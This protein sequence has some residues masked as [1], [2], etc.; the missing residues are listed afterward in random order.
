MENRDSSGIQIGSRRDGE[1]RKEETEGERRERR[2]KEEERGHRSIGAPEVGSEARESR[3]RDASGAL[4]PEREA[5]AGEERG[6][7][8][9]AGWTTG[10]EGGRATGRRER[11]A[12]TGGARGG[13]V[14]REMGAWGGK[15]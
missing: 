5:E 13:V 4:R 8:G 15:G 2:G 11:K 12:E 9:E 10:R 3:R 14:K 1:E 6:R 7:E